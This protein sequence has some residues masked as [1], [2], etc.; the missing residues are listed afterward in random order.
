[1]V[2]TLSLRPKC[3]VSYRRQ[4]FMGGRHERGMRLTFDMQLQGR[5]HAL[6]VNEIAKN[7]YCM[8][9]DWFI[10]EVKINERVPNW[11]AALIAKHGCKL[12]RV[13]KYCAVMA[14]EVGRLQAAWA[15]KENI[16]G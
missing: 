8:P 9:P 11:M 2:R 15:H 10:M 12:Q 1:M 14:H 6:Q 5:T 7:R 3:V 16:Y 4:A 13:S